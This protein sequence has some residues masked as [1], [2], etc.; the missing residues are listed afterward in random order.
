MDFVLAGS[1]EPL[2][3]KKLIGQVY[4]DIIRMPSAIMSPLCSCARDL[5][6]ERFRNAMTFPGSRKT[7]N[8]GVLK[9]N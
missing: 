7:M 9:L 1:G 3:K 4:T 8:R 2:S 6:F 5:S